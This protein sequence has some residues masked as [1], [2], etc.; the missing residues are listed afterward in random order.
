MTLYLYVSAFWG[1]SVEDCDDSVRRCECWLCWCLERL[2]LVENCRP[3]SAHRYGLSRVWTRWCTAKL[4]RSTNPFPQNEHTYGVSPV[5]RRRCTR[6]RNRVLKDLLHSGHGK[7]GFGLSGG[8]GG[9]CD[10]AGSVRPLQEGLKGCGNGKPAC[11]PIIRSSGGMRKQEG[12]AGF[13]RGCASGTARAVKCDERSAICSSRGLVPSNRFSREAGSSDGLNR[14]FKSSRGSKPEFCLSSESN[15]ELLPSNWLNRVWCS[16][17]RSRLEVLSST[18]FTRVS[19]SC[20][21]KRKSLGRSTFDLRLKSSGA[22]ND[23]SSSFRGWESVDDICGGLT[24]QVSVKF[25]CRKEFKIGISFT[26]EHCLFV[27]YKFSI[28]YINLNWKT[29]S[30]RSKNTFKNWFT[31]DASFRSVKL[32]ILKENEKKVTNIEFYGSNTVFLSICNFRECQ[33]K[34]EK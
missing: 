30:N 7:E 9:L 8:N 6:S 3:H 10:P 26:L 11:R 4:P 33:W 21:S 1:Q 12:W 27:F 18:W 20:D 13:F 15:W 17:C 24:S 25:S 32:F 5:C 19:R 2:P 14:T 34:N 16:V 28:F 31:S 22:S 29:K 23:R